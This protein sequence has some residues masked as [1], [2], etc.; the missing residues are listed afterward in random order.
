MSARITLSRSMIPLATLVAGPLADQIF[1]PA[2]MPGGLLAPIF[3][4]LIGTSQGSGIS[5]LIIITGLVITAL[6]PVGLSIPSI[7]N[8]EFLLEDYATNLP[9]ETKASEP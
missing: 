8:A 1:E 3:G 6:T 5:L 4:K 7:R 9:A 2:M